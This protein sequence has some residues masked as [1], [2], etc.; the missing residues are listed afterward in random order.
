MR[1]VGR[2]M[3]EEAPALHFPARSSCSNFTCSQPC[4]SLAFP[5]PHPQENRSCCAQSSWLYSPPS[6]GRPSAT[7]SREYWSCGDTCQALLGWGTLWRLPCCCLQDRI[8]AIP[9]DKLKSH[10]SATIFSVSGKP[11]NCYQTF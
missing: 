5:S 2:S 9:A 6:A 7:R 1:S 4:I 3:L 8:M 11:N 10:I